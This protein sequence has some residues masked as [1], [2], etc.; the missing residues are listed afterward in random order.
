MGT[1]ETVSEHPV[2]KELM[3]ILRPID[4]EPNPEEWE[5]KR[6]PALATRSGKRCTKQPKHRANAE[7]LYNHFRLM[8]KW[9]ETGHFFNQLR[10]F[11]D[12]SHCGWHGPRAIKILEAWKS[13]C[14]TTV[15]SLANEP[16]TIGGVDHDSPRTYFPELSTKK[17][18]EPIL[19]EETPL[20]SIYEINRKAHD[21]VET[22]TDS[23]SNMTI[24]ATNQ[25][26]VIENISDNIDAGKT[27]KIIG[28]G[29]A[30]IERKGSL[31]NHSPIFTELHK[32]LTPQQ[33]EH[34]LVYVLE[35]TDEKGLF[36]IGWTRATAEKSLNQAGNCS[37][38]DVD[39]LH[40]TRSGHFFAASKAEKLAQTVL[41]HHN[42]TIKECEKCGGG[43]RKWFR[44]PK[45]MVI[46]TVEIM[47]T[48]VQLPAYEQKDDGTWKL[49]DA[50]FATIRTMCQFSTVRLKSAMTAAEVPVERPSI[51]G[52]I[53]DVPTQSNLEEVIHTTEA[54]GS[55]I[56]QDSDRGVDGQS[57]WA[58][59]ETIESTKGAKGKKNSIGTETAKRTKR[60]IRKAG[61][62]IDRV[63]QSWSRSQEGTLDLDGD[64]GTTNTGIRNETDLGTPDVKEAVTGVL[65]SLFPEDIKRRRDDVGSKEAR[66]G[67]VWAKMVKQDLRAIVTDFKVEWQRESEED[68]DRPASKKE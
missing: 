19:G 33:Q 34:G 4:I 10:E 49:S 37:A 23:I 54:T 41:R 61:K 65:W 64:D 42:L 18:T 31:R 56:S 63:G 60:A 48:F 46:E 29:L 22:A 51:D 50:A 27:E 45:E 52:P 13:I 55:P 53:G 32:P 47:E 8:E 9:T 44:A 35:H 21:D 43:H 39:I 26:E 20:E 40:Q 28:L 68:M 6:C 59:S 24:T 36:K 66:G 58:A 30:T 7:S 11:L 67:V 3:L 15:P 1:N 16:P 57:L 14:E 62:I 2:F 25:T 5:F 17:T 12:A 38:S